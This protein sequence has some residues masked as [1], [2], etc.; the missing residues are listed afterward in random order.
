MTNAT[1]SS[2]ILTRHRYLLLFLL[3]LLLYVPFLAGRDMWYPDEPDIAEV[4]K[5]MYES[6]DWISPRRVG[7]IWVDYPPMIYWTATVSAHA[8]G[9]YSEFAFRLPTA[10]AAIAL[11]LLT[12]GVGSRWFN[13]RAG[14]WAGF[15]L[16]TFQHYWYNAINYRPDVQ[17]ALPLAAGIFVYAAGAGDRPRWLLRVGGFALLGVA[18]L[19]KGPLGLLLPGLVFVLWHGSRREWRRILELAPLSL[20]SLA[21]YMPWFA[22]CAKAMGSDNILYELYAQNF[23]RF[24]SGSRGHEQPFYYFFVNVWVDLFP[25]SFL[26]PFAI[27]WIYRT[28]LKRD[29]NVQLCL[30]WFGTFIVFLSIAAT[31]RQLYLLPAYPA[32]ALMLAP[33]IA[34]VGREDLP[35]AESPPARP[36]RVFAVAMA[37]LF[38]F[39]G[40]ILTGAA[41]A[42]DRVIQLVE[43]SEL[44]RATASAWRAPGAAIGVTFLASAVWVYLAWR[45]R[46]V[47]RSLV[48]IGIANILVYLLLMAWLF[49]AMNPVRTFR[50]QSEWIRARIGDETHIGIL[51]RWR[52]G[53]KKGGFAL[54]AEV[55]V[56]VM[57][58]EDEVG[59]FFE[60]H[61][62][63][64]VLIQE[65]AARETVRD[66]ERDWRPR[67]IHEFQAGSDYYLVVRGP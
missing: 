4:G 67:V 41:I 59:E 30:W 22:A 38:V 9:G 21:V 11:V 1:H 61:P 13:A 28:A 64:V 33:W 62:T 40:A 34:S 16:L 45:R 24:V 49:P 15:M 31:K 57:E 2:S 19:A 55:L 37:G 23:A 6:G 58:E 25:W 10:L 51:D 63:S 42:F 18:M 66:F 7:V 17:F 48:R 50:P 53:R 54:Y 43:M 56:D 36:A 8:L 26:L 46:A 20:V 3:G 65:R 47:Q 5:V 14:L 27:W 12:S 52:G 32:A 29:R 60:R 39:L 35:A 44:E